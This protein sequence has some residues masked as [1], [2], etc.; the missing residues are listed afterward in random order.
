MKE[1]VIASLGLFLLGSV[2]AAA[3]NG[4]TTPTPPSPPATQTAQAAA[5]AIR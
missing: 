5:S 3:Q 1:K 2:L 4:G